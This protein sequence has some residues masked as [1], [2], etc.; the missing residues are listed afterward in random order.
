LKQ[1][2]ERRGLSLRALGKHVGLTGAAISNY[3]HARYRIAVDRLMHLAAALE[4]KP[5]ALLK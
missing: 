3:E 4:C 5:S 2:R 1:A